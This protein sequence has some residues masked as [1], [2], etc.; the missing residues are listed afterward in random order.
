M[1][2][3]QQQAALS[4]WKQGL[5]SSLQGQRKAQVQ[6]MLVYLDHA[7]V[8]LL[9]AAAKIYGLQPASETLCSIL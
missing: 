7:S 1:Q 4:R 9:I 3:V 2:L 5:G 8:E 6:H